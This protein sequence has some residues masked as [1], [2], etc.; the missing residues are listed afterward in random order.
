MKLITDIGK[1]TEDAIKNVSASIN[2]LYMSEEVEEVE[3]ESLG[4]YEGV[5]ERD[6]ISQYIITGSKICV[7]G[8]SIIIK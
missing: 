3:V 2:C 8:S 4:E 7:S 1:E 6:K 5:S